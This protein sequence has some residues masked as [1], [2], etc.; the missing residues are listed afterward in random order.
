MR[1]YIYL[2]PLVI[3]TT[4]LLTEVVTK[5]LGISNEPI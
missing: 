1:T 3:D 5:Q 2:Q 4:P